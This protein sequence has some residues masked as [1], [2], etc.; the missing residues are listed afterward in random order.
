M[1]SKTRSKEIQKRIDM[2][3]INRSVPS[4][5]VY[6]LI[7]PITFLPTGFYETE[8]QVSWTFTLSTWFMCVL[9]LIYKGLTKQY[10]DKMPA[11]W[12]RLFYACSLVNGSILGI[13]FALVFYNEAYNAMFVIT[14]VIIAGMASG[15]LSALS[16]NMFIS[17]VYPHVLVAP[18]YLGFLFGY[19]VNAT[20]VAIAIYAFYLNIVSKVA[21]QEYLRTFDIEAELAKQKNELETLSQTDALT[22]IFNRGHFNSI[23][24]VSWGT[25][26]RKQSYLVFML[27]DVDHFKKVNDRYGHLCGDACLINIAKILSSHFKRNTDVLCRFGGEEFAGLIIGTELEKV[28]EI[29]ENIRVEIQNTPQHFDDQTFSVTVSIGIALAHPTRHCKQTALIDEADQA[30][31][32]AKNEGRNRTIIYSEEI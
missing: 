20:M 26:M 3:L 23:Y 27:I 9:R 28:F 19:E 7:F 5:V 17:V 15:G 1:V 25:A 10:Y 18:V 6:A 2:E 11:L 32:R 13:F 22:G 12:M 29:A 14:L 8:P 21:N 30:L 4:L 16:P 31:Y 24:A